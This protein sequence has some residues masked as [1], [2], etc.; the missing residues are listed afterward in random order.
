[1][2]A[3]KEVSHHI[4]AKSDVIIFVLFPRSLFLYVR[5]ST[6]TYVLQKMCVCDCHF[7]KL[8]FLKK[9]T[10]FIFWRSLVLQEPA[11]EVWRVPVTL[12]PSQLP[13]FLIACVSVLFCHKERPSLILGGWV[14][15]GLDFLWV[16][17][18][19]RLMQPPRVTQNSFAAL[20]ISCAPP[21]HPHLPPKPWQTPSFL[22]SPWFC[23]FQ[24]ITV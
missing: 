13:L 16:W 11:Y 20:K 9:L 23:L 19:I 2:F 10:L 3:S 18:N 4:T 21:V 15:P 1:M 24:N 17:M 22:L 8:L 12:L 7:S 14:P 5:P 6:R